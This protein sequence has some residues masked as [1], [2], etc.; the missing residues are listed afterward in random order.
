MRPAHLEHKEKIPQSAYSASST[1]WAI[2]ECTTRSRGVSVEGGR[3]QGKLL[4]GRRSAGDD[5]PVGAGNSDDLPEASSER[6]EEQ[7]RTVAIRLNG[8]AGGMLRQES[9]AIT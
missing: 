5:N 9:D 8:I 6:W 3:P 1:R 2:R 7:I 4:R